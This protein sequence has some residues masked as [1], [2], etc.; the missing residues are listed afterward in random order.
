MARSEAIK[1]ERIVTLTANNN[2]WSASVDN[3]VFVVFDHVESGVQLDGLNTQ[4][5]TAMGES[6]VT[7]I[8][9]SDGDDSTTDRCFRIFL[10]G[11]SKVEKGAC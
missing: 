11:Q 3:E 5:I 4:T 9:I 1:R 2:T 7:N 8:L 6:P 10:S